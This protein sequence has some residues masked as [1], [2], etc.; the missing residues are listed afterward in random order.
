MDFD[1]IL[2]TIFLKSL[3][4]EARKLKLHLSYVEFDYVNTKALTQKHIL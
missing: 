1:K 4:F 2:E 3:K